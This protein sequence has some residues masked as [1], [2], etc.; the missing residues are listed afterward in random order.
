MIAAP[1]PS[2]TT[3]GI[4]LSSAT[5]R[6]T[7]AEVGASDP[8]RKASSDVGAGSCF[9]GV[10]ERIAEARSKGRHERVSEDLR[11]CREP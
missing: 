6:V 4:E 7:I 2:E 11:H 8:G 9:E 3:V 1:S 5:E 10:R